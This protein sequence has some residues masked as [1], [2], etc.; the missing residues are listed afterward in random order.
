MKREGWSFV[1]DAMNGR[2]ETI[3]P[4]LRSGVRLD[5][6]L[7]ILGQHQYRNERVMCEHMKS[8]TGK[9]K[10]RLGRVR[11]WSLHLRIGGHLVVHVSEK[12]G[13]GG[14]RGTDD[15]GIQGKS[16]CPREIRKSSAVL[17][18]S[19]YCMRNYTH[20]VVRSHW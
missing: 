10:D 11:I 2:W 15:V 13:G 19:I 14:A 9:Y 8:C 18:Y 7:T 5:C 1:Y 20:E 4:R 3:R 6:W 16:S 12:A 17:S